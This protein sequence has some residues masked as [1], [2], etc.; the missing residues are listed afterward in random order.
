[1]EVER[2]KGEL[3]NGDD[4][5]FWPQ[6]NRPSL[7]VRVGYRRR[8]SKDSRQHCCNLAD[9][10]SMIIELRPAGADKAQD[11]RAIQMQP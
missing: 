3:F 8:T 2:K 9:I 4:G 11:M 10:N 5:I 1:M 6:I 7:S